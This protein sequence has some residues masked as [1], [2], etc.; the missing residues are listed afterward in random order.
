[1]PIE[2]RVVFKPTASIKRPQFTWDFKN[3]YMTNLVCDGRHD[4]CYML[5]CPVIV[6]AVACISLCTLI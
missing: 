6:E 1:M 2:F 4:V 5:R 3:G